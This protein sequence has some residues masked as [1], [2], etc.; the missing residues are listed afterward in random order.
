MQLWLS[1]LILKFSVHILSLKCG[2]CFISICSA[3]KLSY[4]LI[5]FYYDIWKPRSEEISEDFRNGLWFCCLLYKQSII[6]NLQIS[7]EKSCGDWN[8]ANCLIVWK[9]VSEAEQGV[10]EYKS[11]ALKFP[12]VFTELHLWLCST[13]EIS[14]ECANRPYE[15]VLSPSICHFLTGLIGKHL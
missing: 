7:Q 13:T 2:Q 8:E 3:S 10:V 14:C 6:S 5:W 1:P 12:H 4:F 9:F 11:R 15:N